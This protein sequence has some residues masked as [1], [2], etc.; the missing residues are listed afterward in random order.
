MRKMENKNSPSN[1]VIGKA[2]GNCDRIL[3]S[4]NDSNNND[5]ATV[6]TMKAVKKDSSFATSVKNLFNKSSS[7]Q[8]DKN[9]NPAPVPSATAL[10]NQG[11][12]K[13]S[14][15]AAAQFQLAAAAA[16]LNKMS[17]RNDV[18]QLKS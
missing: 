13:V 10:N 16:N 3:S 18:D 8:G 11:Y 1:A 6:T 2:G 17:L 4:P 12:T 14:V 9:N 7:S 5:S 15:D